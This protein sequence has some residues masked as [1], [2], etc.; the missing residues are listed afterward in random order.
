[1]QLHPAAAPVPRQPRRPR[2]PL[3]IVAEVAREIERLLVGRGR[4]RRAGGALAE[5][6]DALADADAE[7]FAA[8]LD[9]LAQGSRRPAAA[10]GGSGRGAARDRRD[11][12]GRRRGRRCS[13][14]SAATASSAPT[15]P[16]QPRSPPAPRSRPPT[17]PREPALVARRHPRRDARSAPPTTPGTPPRRRST[18]APDSCFDR[19]RCAG[20]DELVGRCLAGDQAAWDELVQ[21]YSRYVY[22]IVSQG[23]RLQGADAEDAFQEVFLRVYDRLGSLRDPEALRPWIAQLTRRVCLDRLERQA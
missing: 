16:A 7:V 12:G 1:M 19:G 13:S 4:R 2:R 17:R 20:D 18:R 15:P 3:R 11:R 22:A 23:Y 9:A 8:A 14:P 21:R 5:R 6:L 10:P